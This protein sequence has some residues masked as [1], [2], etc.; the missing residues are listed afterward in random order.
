MSRLRTVDT[1]HVHGRSRSFSIGISTRLEDIL[2]PAPVSAEPIPKVPASYGQIGNRNAGFGNFSTSPRAPYETHRPRAISL[3]FIET[4]LDILGMHNSTNLSPAKSSAHDLSSLLSASALDGPSAGPSPQQNPPAYPIHRA[5]H[6]H[7]RSASVTE[8]AG[9]MFGVRRQLFTSGA[10]DD[11]LGLTVP[12]NSDLFAHSFAEHEDDMEAD[13]MTAQAE[14]HHQRNSTVAALHAASH[15]HLQQQSEIFASSHHLLQQQQHQQ[16]QLLQLQLQQQQQH[17]ERIHPQIPT[18]S[19]WIGNIDPALTAAE[20]LGC[21]SP[22]G[23]IESLR[24]LPEKEC[25]FV[26]YTR[27]EDAIHARDEMQGGRVGN[28]IVRVGFGRAEGLEQAAAAAAA[29]AIATNLGSTASQPT[30]A[31]WIGNISPTTNPA[32]LAAIFGPFGPIDSCRVL[33]HKNCGFVNYEHVDD[34]IR[35]RRAMHGQEIGGLPVRIGFAKVPPNTCSATTTPQIHLSNARTNDTFSNRNRMSQTTSA[36]DPLNP[37]LGVG[38]GDSM[39]GGGMGVSM[40][41]GGIGPL[42][43][44]LSSPGNVAMNS[45]PTPCSSMASS[46]SALP[47]PGTLVNS[48]RSG[49]LEI[50]ED[51][52]DMKS[53]R[54]TPTDLLLS[55]WTVWGQDLVNVDDEC[56]NDEKEIFETNE[57][58]VVLAA[59]KILAS[60]AGLCGRDLSEVDYVLEERGCDLSDEILNF[61]YA[62]TVPPIPEPKPHRKVDQPRLREL[63]KRL[64]ASHPSSKD[65]EAAFH[66]CYDDSV[67]LCSDYIGN[68]VIQ[69][70]AERCNDSLKLKLYQKIAPHLAAIGVHKNGTWAVQKIIDCAKTPL[71]IALI[72]SAL[73]PYAPPLLLD[74]FGNYVVQC[75]LRLGPR[76]NR[77][78]FEAMQVRCWDIA[79]GRFGARAM[80]T[81][82]ESQYATKTQKKMVA[83]AIVENAL[84]LATNPNGSILLTWLLDTS[85]LP[86]RYLLVAPRFISHLAAL[87]VHKLASLTVL[88]IVNQRQE[89]EARELVLRHLFDVN[90]PRSSAG[91][92]CVLEEVLSDQ[93][94]GVA[95]VQKC[96]ASQVM[97]EGEQVAIAERVRAVL[98]RMQAHLVPGY[99]RLMEEVNGIVADPHKQAAVAR[100]NRQGST[101]LY[102]PL[103]PSVVSP[104]VSSLSANGSGRNGIVELLSNP[105]H[106]TAN[107]HSLF[108]P[109]S[110]QPKSG[111]SAASDIN[112]NNINDNLTKINSLQSNNTRSRVN[113]SSSVPPGLGRPTASGEDSSS[114]NSPLSPSPTQPAIHT[115]QL[116]DPRTY[117]HGRSFSE[118]DRRA[119]VRPSGPT[120]MSTLDDLGL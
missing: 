110:T 98:I 114:S 80:R 36:T 82:L 111:I 99:K 108:F 71:Q 68:T 87:S 42:G 95:L 104:S 79:Q 15:T 32:M 55:P 3:G 19:L 64:D 91:G 41:L 74:Q 77:F 27:I 109:Y 29:A 26:N 43:G 16:Q 75:C 6:R 2:G 107:S 7:H 47:L 100:E 34:A 102:P 86:G 18:R 85:Q 40:G 49:N 61:P 24:M 56:D 120:L 83:I 118:F 76:Y 14:H 57:E 8:E 78:V 45:N 33:T 28:C 1:Q 38:Y 115:R 105:N 5:P 58:M 112:S 22:F 25:A 84:R 50:A 93:V 30:R 103:P 54:I 60:K 67:E 101:Y 73:K 96:M 31:L 53:N 113:V 70:L 65:M 10:E 72:T 52:T 63:R 90:P 81:C 94:H 23:P 35:A 48:V 44:L 13:Y 106:Q 119:I 117:G 11:G 66:E 21:F 92:P 9:G 17:E 39:T 37:L 97:Q 69:K 20:L 88:K 59:A 62:P 12:K 4:P 116:F 46:S 51:R 89:P